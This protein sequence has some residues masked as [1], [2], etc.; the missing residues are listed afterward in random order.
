MIRVLVTGAGG[1][2]GAETV[3]ALAGRA[4]VVAHDRTTLD[5]SNPGEITSRI[6][7]ARPSVIVNAAAYT[8][9][10]KAESEPQLARA[11][12]GIA[13]GIIA[14]EAKALGALLIHFSTDYVFDGAKREPYVEG[15]ATHPLGVY[16]ATKLEGERAV[17]Q[18]GCAHVTLRTAWVYGPA[19]KNFMLTMLRL[20]DKGGPVR[21]VDDQRGAPTSSAQIARAV[22]LLLGGGVAV[23][24]G[25]IERTA[26]SSGIYHA[27]ASGDTTWHGF[28]TAIFEE[29]ARRSKEFRMPQVIPI[30]TAEYPTPAKRPAYS[31]LSNA[32]LVET[33][34][35]RL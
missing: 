14:A 23:S 31:V 16:G 4:D 6:R 27:T 21:V 34:G 9:V 24:A 17:A 28:A 22:V 13:P 25:S 11:V 18:S 15:D 33:L 35:I 12:N 1:Q 2:V 19:G 29:R 32:K 8:A 26:A 3:R 5:L 7:E 10:D 20:A 30:T